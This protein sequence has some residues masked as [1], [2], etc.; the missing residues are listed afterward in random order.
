MELRKGITVP[1]G[2][3][4]PFQIDN[5]P[6]GWFA[7]DGTNGSPDL[8]AIPTET[9]SGNG[10]VVKY[11][12]AVWCMFNWPEFHQQHPEWMTPNTKLK[13]GHDN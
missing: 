3:L 4:H 1:A 10:T 2:Y 9:Q 6:D 5:I 12:G 13:D 8:S 7:M 11:E